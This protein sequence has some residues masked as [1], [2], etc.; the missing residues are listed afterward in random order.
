MKNLFLELKCEEVWKL[1]FRSSRIP[2]IESD[3]ISSVFCIGIE[4][5]R[6]DRKELWKIVWNTVDYFDM[7]HVEHFIFSLWNVCRTLQSNLYL[8]I[9]SH[10]YG[11]YW[12]YFW[13]WVILCSNEHCM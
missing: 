2:C 10:F 11:N 8:I 6:T 12:V 1:Y 13:D 3:L 5:K 4:G 9:F 7:F